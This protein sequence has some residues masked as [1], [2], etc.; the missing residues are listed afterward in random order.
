MFDQFGPD[1]S[2]RPS[3]AHNFDQVWPKVRKSGQILTNSLRIEAIVVMS[4]PNLAML[5]PIWARCGPTLTNFG[6][7]W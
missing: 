2:V 4:E 6:R 1:L 5:R 3:V 7:N